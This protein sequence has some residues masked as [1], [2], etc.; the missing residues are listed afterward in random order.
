VLAVESAHSTVNLD[1]IL[2]LFGTFMVINYIL[3]YTVFEER[4]S[5]VPSDNQ[6][7]MS[8]GPSSPASD[9]PTTPS[10]STDTSDQHHMQSSLEQACQM[11]PK[12]METQPEV[13][14]PQSRKDQLGDSLCNTSVNA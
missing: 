8:V 14:F 6:K 9:Q 1:L 5:I 4:P 3:G 12:T 7:C 10:E 2:K 11:K 13:I